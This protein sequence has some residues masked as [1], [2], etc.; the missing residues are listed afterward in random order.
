MQFYAACIGGAVL[1][2]IN[3]QRANAPAVAL[4]VEDIVHIEV[5]GERSVEEALERTHIHRCVRLVLLRSA[6]VS[7]YRSA[8]QREPQGFVDDKPVHQTRQELRLT[9]R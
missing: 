9:Q 1:V 2:A 8:L 3:P 6:V 4:T 5:A 7:G